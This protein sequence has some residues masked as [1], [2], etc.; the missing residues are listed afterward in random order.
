VLDA[1][2]REM[3]GEPAAAADEAAEDASARVVL[4]RG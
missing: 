2:N 4:L 3:I 1:A